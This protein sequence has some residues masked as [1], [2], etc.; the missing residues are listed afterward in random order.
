MDYKEQVRQWLDKLRQGTLKEADLQ[1]ALDQFEGRDYRGAK[2]QRLLYLQTRTTGT[3]SEVLGMSVVEEGQVREGADDPA[4]WPYNSV[5]EALND[6]WRVVKFP[7]L[8][9]LLQED[10]TIGLGCEFILEK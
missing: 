3:D 2:I 9:L 4:E 6:G 8:A 5:I 7:E 1:Q 10:K